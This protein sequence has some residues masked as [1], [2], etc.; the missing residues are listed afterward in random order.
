MRPGLPRFSRSS[1]SVYYTERKPK[2]KKRG[3]PGNKAMKGPLASTRTT[4]VIS[5]FVDEY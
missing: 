1:T 3:R 2:N 5:R 4:T